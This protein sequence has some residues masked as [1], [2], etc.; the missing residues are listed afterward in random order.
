MLTVPRESG[1]FRDF[2]IAYR[3]HQER[4][5][6]SV[7]SVCDV[8]R[9]DPFGAGTFAVIPFA[10]THFGGGIEGGMYAPRRRHEAGARAE[11]RIR[12]DCRRSR[13]DRRYVNGDLQPERKSGGPTAVECTT[14]SDEISRRRGAAPT[15]STAI[16]S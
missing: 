16:A 3:H 2:R 7:L 9:C 4:S 6:R 15:R 14:D 12:T 13:V 1:C 10:G 11:V 5:A 8:H